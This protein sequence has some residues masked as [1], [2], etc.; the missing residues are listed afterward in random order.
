MIG[1]FD[2][3]DE[4]GRRTVRVGDDEARARRNAADERE[5]RAV[6]RERRLG[7][8]VAI[9]AKAPE[10]GKPCVAYLG[11]RSAGH[12][13][14]M[15]HNGIEYGDMQLIAEAYN[16][17]RQALGLEAA[18]LAAI[19][20]EWNKGELDSY[21]IS[22]TAQIFRRIDDLTGKPLVDLV[23]DTAT[24]SVTRAGTPI[25]LMP[26]GIRLL[27]ILMRAS[28]RVVSRQQLENE[29]WGDLLPDSDTLRSHLYALRRAIDKPFGKSLLHTLPG[30]GYR[31]SDETPPG[32]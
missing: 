17:L 30:L 24:L 7:G 25:K 9:A 14:K 26:I 8:A 3:R 19:F 4:R 11:P 13:V 10:D 12:Y 18:E 6:G 29:V 20:D 23:L 27:T 31:I 15:V 28:P 16:I 21:L 1:V 22:I 32:Q 2:R 5:V